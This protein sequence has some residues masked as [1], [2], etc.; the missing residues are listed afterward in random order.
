M[1]EFLTNIANSAQQSF[2]ESEKEKVLMQPFRVGDSRV[3][4]FPGDIRSKDLPF[5]TFTAFGKTSSPVIALPVPPGLSIGDGMSYSTINLGIIGT[6]MAETLTQMGKQDTITGV[7]GAGVGGMAGSLINKAKQMNA[8]AAASIL[9]RRGGFETFADAVDLSQRQVI[10]PNT[11]TTF[12]NSNIRS[13]AFTFKMVSRTK[14]EAATIKR[15]VE[16]LREYMYPEGKDVILEYPPIWSIEFND[17]E[18]TVNPFLPKIYSSYLTSLTTSFNSTTNIY[19]EDGSP[20]ETDIA[21]AFQETKALT[22]GD[23]KALAGQKS[24]SS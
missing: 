6:I 5:V 22:R 21:I 23:I 24:N 12:Q 10:A 8:A 14:A 3:L 2:R 9:A 13:Y 4:A 20:V 19:H 18:G 11:N 7:L 17:R 15:I 16:V 1:P